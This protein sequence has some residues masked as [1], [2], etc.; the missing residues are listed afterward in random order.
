MMLTAT[1]INRRR[2]YRVGKGGEG[3]LGKNKLYDSE[4]LDSIDESDLPSLSTSDLLLTATTAAHPPKERSCMGVSFR[5]PNSS[6]YA[7]HWHSRFLQKFPFLVEFFYWGLNYLFYICA[8]PLAE[9]IFRDE[10]F[11]QTAENHGIA[12]LTLEH[13]SAF[14]FLF[15]LREIDVQQFFMTGHQSALTFLNRMYSLIHIPATVL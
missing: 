9:A 4:D 14:G 5:T 2:G 8:K 12:V 13:D 1:Y 15:P 10:G 7:H 11:W 6:R 3:L